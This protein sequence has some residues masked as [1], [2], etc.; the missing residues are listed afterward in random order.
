MAKAA[1]GVATAF[2]EMR[3]THIKIRARMSKE[4][5]A[6]PAGICLCCCCLLVSYGFLVLL[7]VVA[8]AAAC[9]SFQH[10]CCTGSWQSM[11]ALYISVMLSLQFRINVLTSAGGCGR[12]EGGGGCTRQGVAGWR[13]H[14]WLPIYTCM[15]PCACTHPCQ[16][17]YNPGDITDIR[18]YVHVPEGRGGRRGAANG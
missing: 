16:V 12:E 6:T 13:Q 9:C 4:P 7:L 2:A 15:L 11:Q 8:D 3:A 10:L 14:Q 1:N 5:S 18:A 17:F